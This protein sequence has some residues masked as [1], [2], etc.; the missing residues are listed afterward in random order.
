MAYKLVKKHFGIQTVET[1]SILNEDSEI[2]DVCYAPPFGFFFTAGHAISLLNEDGAYIS[3][4]C[5]SKEEAAFLNV[6]LP[7]A[8]FDRPSSL[9]YHKNKNVLYVCE[10]NGA[11][12]RKIDLKTFSV[13]SIFKGSTQVQVLAHFK[14][15]ANYDGKTAVCVGPNSSIYWISEIT[16]KC[17]VYK[18]SVLKTIIGTGKRGFS[19]CS[20]LAQS[21]IDRPKGLSYNNGAMHLVDS[22]NGC[23]RQIKNGSKIV[24]GD[25]QTKEMDKMSKIAINK[26]SLYVVNDNE[27]LHI[28][29]GSN[30][31]V[32]VYRS[33]G[34]I[35][36]TTDSNHNLYILEEEHGS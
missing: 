11:S 14:K 15:A 3:P 33:D 22:G 18:G 6:N 30:N 12:I 21:M 25:P 24:F 2:R 31:V 26:S 7:H 5:G 17:F 29:I 36:I 20:I 28:T 34:I 16:N 13:S 27:V 4:W 19:N 8:R 23:I 35:S 10:K 1:L 9:C 32:P